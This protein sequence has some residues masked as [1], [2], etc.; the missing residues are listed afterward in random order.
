MK[1]GLTGTIRSEKAHGKN[2]IKCLNSSGRLG[3][4]GTPGRWPSKDVFFCEFLWQ[5][6]G[7]PGALANRSLL[8]GV[9]GTPG[10]CLDLSFVYVPCSFLKAML[11]RFILN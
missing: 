3:V 5:T 11:P 9:P 10:G 7:I 6:A 2:H 8:L 1:G 4:P